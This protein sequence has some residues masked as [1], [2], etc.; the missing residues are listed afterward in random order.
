MRKIKH[1]NSRQLAIQLKNRQK[2][3]ARILKDLCEKDPLFI[4]VLGCGRVGSQLVNCLLTYGRVG[5]N[6]M[7]ISTRR[8]ETLGILLLNKMHS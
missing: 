7:A 6:E 5:P 1:L 8:P 4:G 2:R 3:K